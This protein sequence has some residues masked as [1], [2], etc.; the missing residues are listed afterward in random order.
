MVNVYLHPTASTAPARVLDI[1]RRTG[2][3]AVCRGRKAVLMSPAEAGVIG[4]PLVRIQRQ[5]QSQ[6]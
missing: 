3:V 4:H 2:L 5:R 1:E 6:R